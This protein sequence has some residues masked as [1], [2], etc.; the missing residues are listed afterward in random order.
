[1]FKVTIDLKKIWI[2]KISHVLFEWI[3]FQTTDTTGMVIRKNIK[4]V[5]IIQKLA[6]IF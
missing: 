3:A 4:T 5:Q 2:Q 1:M 6:S